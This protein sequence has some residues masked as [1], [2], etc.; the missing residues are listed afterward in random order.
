MQQIDRRRLAML[1]A[2]AAAVL[3]AGAAAAQPVPAVRPTNMPGVTTSAEPPE[4]FDAVNASDAAL[5]AYGFPPR[6]DAARNPVGHAHWAAAVGS[7]AQRLVPQLQQTI[8]AHGPR[9]PASPGSIAGQTSTSTN[10]SG[11][12]ADVG[13]KS[14]GAT[15]FN[16]VAAEF[17]VPAVSARVCDP[18]NDGEH[19]E[20]SSA[21]VGID[22]Y[23][24]RDVL[25]AG[26]EADADLPCNGSGLQTYYSPWYEWYPNYETRITNLGAAPGQ[27]FSVHVWP[28]SATVGNAYLLNVSTN[29][30]VSITFPAPSGTTLL[31][32]SAE[33][34]MES[35]TVS[36]QLATLPF[37]GLGYFANATSTTGLKVVHAPGSP[38]SIAISLVDN[39]ITYSSPGLLGI[40]GILFTSH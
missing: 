31:G 15:S 3:T 37:Y 35:P 19:W 28:S 8:I 36:G 20:Y 18:S 13:T 25:Q 14:F 16:S 9:R 29:Q 11:Y 5:A 12:A 24:S 38:S 30:S 10:W 2:G 1:V 39:K 23:A 22:G 27:S 4:G 21:W 33:W 17:V 6:P 34:I 26:V 40:G 32:E 7:H